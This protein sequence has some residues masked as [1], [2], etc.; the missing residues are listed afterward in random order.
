MFFF[1]YKRIHW[2]LFQKQYRQVHQYRCKCAYQ[3]MKAGGE[4]D[5]KVKEEE[6]ITR[7]NVS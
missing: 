1:R 5:P 4:E 6:T 3:I 2:G 7:I